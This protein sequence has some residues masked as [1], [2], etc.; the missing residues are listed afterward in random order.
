[1]PR[2]LFKVVAPGEVFFSSAEFITIDLV[3]SSI[4]QVSNERSS[5]NFSGIPDLHRFSP[6]LAPPTVMAPLAA[7]EMIVHD[8]KNY[9]R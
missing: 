7:V 2:F 5:V 3:L 8:V 4:D 9:A 6:V 1:M